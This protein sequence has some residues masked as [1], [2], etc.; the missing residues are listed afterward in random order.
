MKKIKLTEKERRE[1]LADAKDPK[2]RQDF[3]TARALAPRLTFEEYLVW[4]TQFTE[5]FPERKPRKFVEYRR[6]LL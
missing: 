6:S 2:R 3:R 1:M 4:L 5:L